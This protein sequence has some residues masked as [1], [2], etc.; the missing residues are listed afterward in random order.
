MHSGITTVF[1]VFFF[2][3]TCVSVVL[4]WSQSDFP[5]WKIPTRTPTTESFSQLSLL[6]DLMRIRNL[7]LTSQDDRY[8]PLLRSVLV[9]AEA[10]P[11]RGCLMSMRAIFSCKISISARSYNLKY[12]S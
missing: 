7:P 12:Q 5:P 6:M 3:R 11:G 10:E 9:D 1:K 2:A 8:F 4:F